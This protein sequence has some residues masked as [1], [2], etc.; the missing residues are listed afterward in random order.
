VT[1]FYGILHT[2]TGELEY[3]IGGH[4]P[5]YRVTASGELSTIWEPGGVVVG[6]LPDS[7]YETGRLQLAPGDTVFLYT[8]GVT[9]AMSAEEKFFGDRR[10][11]E[12]LAGAGGLEP[13]DAV[14]RVLGAVREYTSGADQSD[15]I[16][17]M[18]VRWT[19]R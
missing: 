5:P 14:G 8:D 17:T 2:D 16:T 15:D 10:L 1:V 7:E 18:A 6:L 19:G 3:C 13:K 11:K 12:I 4:N 9:E